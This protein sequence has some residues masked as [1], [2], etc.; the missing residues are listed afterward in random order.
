[1]NRTIRNLVIAV[2]LTTVGFT[3]VG[4]TAATAG[5]PNDPN[6]PIAIPDKPKGPKD[7][8]IPEPKD[9][10]P[11]LPWADAPKNDGPKD[12]APKPQSQPTGP[13]VVAQADQDI[14]VEADKEKAEVVSAHGSADSIDR[15]DVLFV[16]GPAETTLV[17]NDSDN[18]M[19]LTWF[20]VGGGIVTASGIAF[21]ARKRANA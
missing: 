4:A 2:P 5:G 10:K 7:I 16:A 12:K 6:F 20:L 15:S 11:D 3:M 9:P 19:D 14:K 8:A 21:A 13:T 17:A 18:G 1:M